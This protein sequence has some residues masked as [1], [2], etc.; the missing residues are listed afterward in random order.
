M[1]CPEIVDV[2]VADLDRGACAEDLLSEEEQRRGAALDSERARA[3][4]IASRS[5]LRAIV[6]RQSGVD[7]RALRFAHGPHGKPSVA[8]L[9]SQAQTQDRSRELCFNVSHS[10]SLAVY[11]LAW[12]REVGID[13][14]LA[15]RRLH[16]K[17]DELGIAQRLLGAEATA[18]LSRLPTAERA[19]AFLREWIAYEARVKCVG[20]GIGHAADDPAAVERLRNVS[21]VEL[22]V[23][24][25]ALAALAVEGDVPI[26]VRHLWDESGLDL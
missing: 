1:S 18:R 5:I 10:G 8:S 19:G 14:E 9:P 20:A 2:W 11:A 16:G 23:G 6:G 7:P 25:G 15:D 21:V 13:V 4:W 24:P 3:R 12:G 22:A 17:A 26:V